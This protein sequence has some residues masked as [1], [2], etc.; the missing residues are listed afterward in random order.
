MV[1]VRIWM[2]IF[3]DNERIFLPLMLW[4]SNG[5]SKASL[6]FC[7]ECNNLLYPK[8][9]PQRRIMVYGCRICQYDDIVENKCVYRNDLLTVTKCVH[10]PFFLCLNLC[11]LSG[12]KLASRLISVLMLPWYDLMIL[13]D[14]LD[15]S[16]ISVLGSLQH[17]LSPVRQRW[18]SWPPST[19]HL[20][21]RCLSVLSS[22]KI[23]RN[24]KK[25]AWFY[26]LFARSVITASLIRHYPW[27]IGQKH[28]M[29]GT[30]KSYC[31]LLVSIN[32]SVSS[33]EPLLFYTFVEF[34]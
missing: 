8:A 33:P 34:F 31:I 23:N 3:N 2:L 12:S 11:I 13:L 7:Q 32:L 25:L 24:E 16:C 9:D 28:N 10:R 21:W 20:Y 5:S 29:D 15:P 18:V 19:L 27:T 14:A 6:H 26:S 4:I 1:C 17:S 22:I 30:H